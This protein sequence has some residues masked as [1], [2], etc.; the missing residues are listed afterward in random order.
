MC[1][2][3]LQS[4]EVSSYADELQLYYHATKK[5]RSMYQ[6]QEHQFH[7]PTYGSPLEV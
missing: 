7:C 6:K 2:I 3:H 5:F 1:D 4:A